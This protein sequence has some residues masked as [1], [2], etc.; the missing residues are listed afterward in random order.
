MIDST[1]EARVRIT[2]SMQLIIEEIIN[3]SHFNSKSGFKKHSV[4]N[5]IEEINSLVSGQKSIRD[6][7]SRLNQDVKWINIGISESDIENK[8]EISQDLGGSR[9]IEISDEK[10]DILRSCSRS[11]GITESGLIRICIIKESYRMRKILEESS[12]LRLEQRWL[13]IKRKLNKANDLLIQKL[14]FS[15]DSDLVKERSSRDIEKTNVFYLNEHYQRF[16][17]S[18]G[19]NYM[20]NTKE[21]KKI[22]NVIEDAVKTV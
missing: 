10:Y 21:G 4:E 3:K 6:F 9:K 20:K 19:H 18:A 11:S 1:T 12:E 17:D 5:N 13:T 2:K 15:I 14:Y 22:I 16:K 8:L 7:I